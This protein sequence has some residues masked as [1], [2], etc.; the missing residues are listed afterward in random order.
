MEKKKESMY[1]KHVKDSQSLLFS[2]VPS[3]NAVSYYMDDL[4]A[5]GQAEEC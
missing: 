3:G 1:F 4:R 2:R 5:V